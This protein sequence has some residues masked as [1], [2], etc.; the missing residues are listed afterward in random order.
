MREAPP[1]EQLQRSL[2]F[3]DKEEKVTM[4]NTKVW[5]ATCK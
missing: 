5:R 3:L 1:P 4:D 2:V